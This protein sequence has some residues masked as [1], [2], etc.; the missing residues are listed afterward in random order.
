MGGHERVPEQQLGVGGCQRQ[1]RKDDAEQASDADG[2]VRAD[3]VAV[4]VAVREPARVSVV[5]R[6][7]VGA[8]RVRA[9]GGALGGRVVRDGSGGGQ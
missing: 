7:M 2:A 4:D 5:G 9:G 1:R 3:E 6:C 8:L